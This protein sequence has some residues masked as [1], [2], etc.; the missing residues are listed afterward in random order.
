M[1]LIHPLERR[2]MF[3]TMAEYQPYVPEDGALVIEGTRRDDAITLS[4][5]DGKLYINATSGG[6]WLKQGAGRNH[7]TLTPAAG[8]YVELSDIASIRINCGDGRDSVVLGNLKLPALVYGGRGNDTISGGR[9]DDTLLGQ[10][11][12]D[13]IWGGAGNDLLD[14]WIGNDRLEGGAGDDTLQGGAGDDRLFGAGGTNFISGGEGA[15]AQG[16][17]DPRPVQ[18]ADQGLD[19]IDATVERHKANWQEIPLD[20]SFDGIAVRRTADGRV[21]AEVGYTFGTGS[22]LIE[23][24]AEPYGSTGDK[25]V[26]RARAWTSLGGQ[27]ADMYSPRRRVDFGKLADGAYTFIATAGREELSRIKVV[28]NES[29]QTVTQPAAGRFNSGFFYDTTPRRGFVSGGLGRSGVTG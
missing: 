5:D 10:T 9:G 4:V 3:T 18:D 7:A 23:F 1:L 21:E 17:L 12:W 28:V 29:P 20:A 19:L 14:G 6:A 25:F 22:T 13:R 27:T 8:H 15:D 26:I 16:T 2:Q 24:I 11:G